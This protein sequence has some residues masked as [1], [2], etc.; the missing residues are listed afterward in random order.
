MS[1]TNCCNNTKTCGYGCGLDAPSGTTKVGVMLAQPSAVTSSSAFSLNAHMDQG[2]AQVLLSGT[3]W[4]LIGLDPTYGAYQISISGVT[5]NS[6]HCY[7]MDLQI[8]AGSPNQI[9]GEVIDTTTGTS[10]TAVHNVIATKITDSSVK[11]EDNSGTYFFFLPVWGSWTVGKCSLSGGFWQHGFV[12]QGK[13]TNCG[14]ICSKI[15]Y[16]SGTGTIELGCNATGS[17]TCGTQLW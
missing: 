4:I 6:S 7:F 11:T 1:C 15:H 9:K 13:Q 17:P 16:D 2:S 8:I 12:F 5:W 3:S 10:Y 14:A